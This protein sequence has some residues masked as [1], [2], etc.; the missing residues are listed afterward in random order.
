MQPG[1]HLVTPRTCYSHHG[2]YVGNGMVIHYTGK[3][4]GEDGEIRVTTLETFCD[5]KGCSVRPHPLRLYDSKESIA[6]ARQRLGETR[7]NL[8]FRNC[9]HFVTWCIYGVHFSR[10]V[11]DAATATAVLHQVALQTTAAR[12]LTEVGCAAVALRQATTQTGP[13]GSLQVAAISK[14]ASFCFSLLRP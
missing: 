8:L 12:A 3:L 10:Q 2:L 4:D 9:E 11:A 5:G 1:D 6:R 7:Y 14:L 13:G